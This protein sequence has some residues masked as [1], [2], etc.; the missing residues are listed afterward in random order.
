MNQRWL[1]YGLGA[2][3]VFAAVNFLSCGQDHKLV[4]I[5]IHPSGGFTFPTPDPAAQGVF[6]AIGTYV[7]PPR[8][9][10]ITNQVAWKTD[11]P[12][13]LTINNGVVSPQSTSVC[14]I[15]DVSASLTSGGN[16]V[17]A[18]STV[19]VNDP[20]NP[21]CPGGSATQGVVTVTLLPADG[22]VVTSVPAG[23]TCPS[24]TCGAQFTVGDTITL[25]ASPNAGHSFASWSGCTPSGGSNCTLQ[26]PTGSTNVTATF[27]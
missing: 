15:A 14:G 25:T 21:L 24:Q 5:T 26:V 27:N 2:A 7:H 6:T 8:T 23:I 1:K 16:L 9:T 13:L 18:Y 3:F 22:G 19:T 10:D 17:I 4:A 20:T 11:V 12:G